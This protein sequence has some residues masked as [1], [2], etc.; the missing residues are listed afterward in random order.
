LVARQVAATGLSPS[1]DYTPDNPRYEAVFNRFADFIFLP[2]P[3]GKQ[4]G[5]QK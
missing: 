1:V 5:S 3:A 2:S 4:T